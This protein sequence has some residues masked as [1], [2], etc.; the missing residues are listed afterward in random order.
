MWLRE[1]RSYLYI[2]EQHNSSK[3]S[4]DQDTTT[5]LIYVYYRDLKCTIKFIANASI[6][7]WN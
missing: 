7:A 3:H 2:C 4:T 5:A 1:N 6:I